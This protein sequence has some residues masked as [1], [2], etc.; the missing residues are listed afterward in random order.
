MRRRFFVGLTFALLVQPSIAAAESKIDYSSELIASYSEADKRIQVGNRF[1]TFRAGGAGFRF[2]AE[3]DKYGVFYGSLGFGYSPEETASYSGSSL[4]GPAD[5]FFHG[6]GYRYDYDLN[7]RYKLIFSTDY[8]THDITGDLK[9]EVRGLPAV[10]K[11]T[12]DV[13]MYD[14]TLAL[15]YSISRDLHVS[16]GAGKRD[17]KLDALANGTI[18]G[19]IAAISQVTVQGRDPIQYIALEFDISDV[20]V[21]AYYRR[22]SLQADN[23]VTV[24]ELEIQLLFTNF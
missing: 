6:A 22:S 15:R 21:E 17:W 3:H 4:S 2:E 24:H 13:S 14:A 10:A 16:F 18:G 1:A 7:Q 23:S 11:I 19:D 8:V 5:S 9:G 20:P 12:S